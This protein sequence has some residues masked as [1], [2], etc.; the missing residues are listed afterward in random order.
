VVT[1]SGERAEAFVSAST[2]DGSAS[3]DAYFRWSNQPL[4]AMAYLLT[5]EL[6]TAQDL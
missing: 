5:G 1:V 2:D 6:E 4:V 3:F